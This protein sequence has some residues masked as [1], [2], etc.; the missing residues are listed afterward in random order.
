M[1]RLNKPL[2]ICSRPCRSG[3]DSGQHTWRRSGASA[4]LFIGC[5]HVFTNSLHK[6]KR[7]LSTRVFAPDLA[8]DDTL[9]YNAVISAAFLASVALLCV[10]T[11]CGQ[12]WLERCRQREQSE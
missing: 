12:A 4:S 2:L 1:F 11:S 5:L 7:V 8:M 9:Y 10:L 6:T 3:C